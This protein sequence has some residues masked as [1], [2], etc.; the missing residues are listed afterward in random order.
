MR[1]G[2]SHGVWAYGGHTFTLVVI[3]NNVDMSIKIA[4]HL[5]VVLLLRDGVGATS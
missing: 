1:L 3:V 4:T 2:R 5:V